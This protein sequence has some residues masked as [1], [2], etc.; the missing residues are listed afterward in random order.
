M[1]FTNLFHINNYIMM[2]RT[3]IVVCNYTVQLI[4]D[5][6][7]PFNLIKINQLIFIGKSIILKIQFF[8]NNFG[9]FRAVLG[10]FG[11][12]PEQKLRH[13]ARKPPW[14]QYIRVV[15]Y[16]HSLLPFGALE[17]ELHQSWRQTRHAFASSFAL[18]KSQSTTSTSIVQRVVS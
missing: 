17:L 4:T 6:V 8:K 3:R 7:F 16:T 9:Q 18:A 1:I 10:S 5:T 12:C 13:C 14:I 15:E 11:Q 2:L